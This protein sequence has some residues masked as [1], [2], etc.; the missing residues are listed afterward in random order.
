[1]MLDDIKSYCVLKE[2]GTKALSTA[3]RIQCA[4]R[5]L[6]QMIQTMV[7]RKNFLMAIL[8]STITSH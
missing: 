6:I 3:L 7:T 1:M 4:I 8:S 2:H 5:L